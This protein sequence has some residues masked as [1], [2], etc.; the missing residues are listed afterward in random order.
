MV[1]AAVAVGPVT[2][3]TEMVLLVAVTLCQMEPR[4]VVAAA[5]Q[6]LLVDQVRS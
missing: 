2:L 3:V 1:T 4:T 6:A 5:A